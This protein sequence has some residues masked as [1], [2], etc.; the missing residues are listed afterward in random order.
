MNKTQRK[1]ERKKAINEFKAKREEEYRNKKKGI[2]LKFDMSNLSYNGYYHQEEKMSSE[3]PRRP[4]TLSP[5]NFYTKGTFISST[6]S[7]LNNFYIDDDTDNSWQSD[8]ELPKYIQCTD[9]TGNSYLKVIEK[10]ESL[11]ENNT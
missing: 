5:E 7:S 2:K 11:D 6:K 4:I 10:T 9:D 1:I 8:F 3:I